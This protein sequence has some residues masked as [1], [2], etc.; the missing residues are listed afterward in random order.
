V[1]RAEPTNDTRTA[2]SFPTLFHHYP[3]VLFLPVAC[4]QILTFPQNPHNS[5]K[6]THFQLSH[7]QAPPAETPLYI[8]LT[9]AKMSFLGPKKLVQTAA[10]RF[11]L[12]QPRLKSCDITGEDPHPGKR[13]SVTEQQSPIE[14][15]SKEK[16]A[17][18]QLKGLEVKYHRGKRKRTFDAAWKKNGHVRRETIKD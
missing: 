2:I 14:G 1:I 9:Q 11:N 18:L 13:Q 3:C 5:R 17:P 4:I 8:N 16:Q 6:H 7:Q 10:R 15:D 12:C